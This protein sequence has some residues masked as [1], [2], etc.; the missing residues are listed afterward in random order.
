M[1]S[2]E[3]KEVV[4]NVL[5]AE[6]LSRTGGKKS[7]DWATWRQLMTLTGEFSL[8]NGNKVYLEGG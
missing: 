5:Q 1:L 7:L 2:K 8:I 6:E 4:S 3:N